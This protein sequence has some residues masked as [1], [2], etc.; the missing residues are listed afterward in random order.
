[1]KIWEFGNDHSL[2]YVGIS[3]S[4]NFHF[5]TKQLSFETKNQSVFLVDADIWAFG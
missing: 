2:R 3:K 4:P 1:L 5:E